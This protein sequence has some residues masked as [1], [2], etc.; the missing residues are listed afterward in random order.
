MKKGVID[1]DTGDA[2]I[3]GRKI[4]RPFKPV[5]KFLKAMPK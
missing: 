4:G 2:V 5:T 3:S 1:S